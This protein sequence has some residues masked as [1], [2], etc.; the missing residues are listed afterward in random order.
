M[1]AV[2]QGMEPKKSKVNFWLRAVI[3]LFIAEQII[4]MAY[5]ILKKGASIIDYI[6][7]LF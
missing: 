5:V 6:A 7:N 4:F 1:N 2:K 3:I